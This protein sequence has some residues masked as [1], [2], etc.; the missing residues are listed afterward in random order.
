MVQDKDTE[1]VI[2]A[3]WTTCLPKQTSQTR[4]LW[5]DCPCLSK[6]AEQYFKNQRKRTA[7]YAKHKRNIEEGRE[8]LIKVK[9]WTSTEKRLI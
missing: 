7:V 3:Q 9:D 5:R 4:T 1:E 6:G 8:E 2:L